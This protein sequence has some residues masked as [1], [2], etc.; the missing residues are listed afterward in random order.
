M[1]GD[2]TRC[3][4]SSEEVVDPLE[5]DLQAVISPPVW[6]LGTEPESYARTVGVITTDPCLQP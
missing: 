3:L 6:M 1:A 4:W 5:L 2:W